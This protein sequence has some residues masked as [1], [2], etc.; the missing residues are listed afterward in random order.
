MQVSNTKVRGRLVPVSLSANKSFPASVVNIVWLLLGCLLL[1]DTYSNIFLMDFSIRPKHNKA[2]NK[3][4]EK[5][6]G[7]MPHTALWLLALL[8]VA[9]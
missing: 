1:T 8:Y 9:K 4:Q 7:E 2:C 5:S 3:F 6:S